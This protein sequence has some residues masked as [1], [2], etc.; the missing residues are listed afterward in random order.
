MLT[1]AK[2]RTLPGHL[3]NMIKQDTD[4]LIA[5]ILLVNA[6]SSGAS[7]KYQILEAQ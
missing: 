3:V 2:A 5:Q 4:N 7:R 1:E 6:M